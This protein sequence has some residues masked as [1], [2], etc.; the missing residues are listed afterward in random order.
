MYYNQVHVY[1]SIDDQETCS[2][3]ITNNILL[4]VFACNFVTVTYITIY[5]CN[6]AL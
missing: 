1:Y 4:V 5:Y 2:T 6:N 3:S